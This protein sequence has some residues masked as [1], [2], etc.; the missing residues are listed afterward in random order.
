MGTERNRHNLPRETDL[1][2][3]PGDPGH[4]LR[5]KARQG[6]RGQPRPWESGTTPRKGSPRSQ[7]ATTRWA[8][9]GRKAGPTRGVPSVLQFPGDRILS[10][11]R[12]GI[13][14]K[15]PD[16]ARD[17]IH[18]IT[19]RNRGVSMVQRTSEL[20]AFLTGRVTY[21]RLAACK[22]HLTDLDGWIRRELR[23]MLYG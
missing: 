21:F 5:N 16:R 12:V 2:P 1:R 4:R 11:G 7:S 22:S 10:G 18:Q 9:S 3:R 20:S 8:R 6:R 13:A 14:T 19:R 17:R 15:S 23:S